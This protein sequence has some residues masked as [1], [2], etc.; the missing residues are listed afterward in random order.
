MTAGIEILDARP[1]DEPGWR[2][3]WSGFLD[4]YGM[5]LPEEVTGYTWARLLDPGNALS[6]RLAFVGGRMAGFAIHQH[7]PSTWV[8][9]DD[10]YLEDLFVAP[11]ARGCGAG[12]ALIEDLIGLARDRGWIRLYW[13]TDADNHQARSLYDRFARDDG[14]LRYRMVL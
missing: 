6:A 5:T 3:L 2:G 13:H 14:H 9:G 1:E 11:W 10:C 8:K 4:Y 12:R 7:H